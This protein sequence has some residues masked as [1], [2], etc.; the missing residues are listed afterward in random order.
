[1]ENGFKINIYSDSLSSIQ[2]LRSSKSK[3]NIILKI[4]EKLSSVS[5][6][7]GL[8]WVKDHAGNTGNE[9]ADHFAKLATELGNGFEI[10][11]PYSFLKKN[12][13]RD[14]INNWNLSCRVFENGKRV[15]D[16]LPTPD[17]ELLTFNKY[18]VYLFTVHGPFIPYLHRFNISSTPLCLCGIIGDADHYIFECRFTADLHL[19]KPLMDNKNKWFMNVL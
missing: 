10:S 12:I 15:K 7:V 2:A 17:L 19:T 13:K 3:S 4:K 16:F 8:S 14:L 5:G 6:Y 1:M 11:V 9:T 18:L